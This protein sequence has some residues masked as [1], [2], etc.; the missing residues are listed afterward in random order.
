MD[1]LSGRRALK[2]LGLALAIAVAAPALAS[3]V[4]I[5]YLYRGFA[6]GRWAGWISRTPPSRSPL[7]PTP[8]TSAL[9]PVRATLQITHSSASVG[10]SGFGTFS[11]TEP[12]HTWIAEG[13]C[14]GIGA[15]LSFNYLTLFSPAIT[16]SATA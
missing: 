7:R 5:T 10:L 14:M 6:E 11:F 8:T 12:T 2:T 3:A 16:R 9:G 4:P 1:L 15:D 13:C